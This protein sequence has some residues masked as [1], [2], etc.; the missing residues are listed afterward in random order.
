MT[1][2]LLLLLC[3]HDMCQLRHDYFNTK[4]L[5]NG[6]F[7]VTGKIQFWTLQELSKDKFDVRVHVK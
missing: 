2:R 7:R 4:S 6:V 1:R 5:V 3:T